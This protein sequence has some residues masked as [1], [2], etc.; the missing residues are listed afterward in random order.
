MHLNGFSPV[1]IRFCLFSSSALKKSFPQICP[2]TR[3]RYP[4]RNFFSRSIEFKLVE[5]REDEPASFFIEILELELLGVGLDERDVFGCEC[6][7][8]GRGVFGSE[9]RGDW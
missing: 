3:S 4:Q 2:V 1:C 9:F 6:D 7:R 8:V 5:F